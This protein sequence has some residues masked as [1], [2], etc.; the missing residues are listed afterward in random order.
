MKWWSAGLAVSALAAGWGSV[1]QAEGPEGGPPES[2]SV[3]S[4]TPS[5]CGDLPWTGAAWTELLR[6]ELAAD[7]TR[8]HVARANDPAKAGAPRM[9]LEP[10]ACDES[11]RSATLTLEL[12][13]DRIERAVD[14]AQVESRTRARVLALAAVELIHASRARLAMEAANAPAQEE[15]HLP[16]RLVAMGL[17]DHE[18]EPRRVHPFGLFAAGDGRVFVEGGAALLGARV[19][20]RVPLLGWSALVIDG[21]FLLGAARDP[22]G[23][24]DAALASVGLGALAMGGSDR[25]SLG[26][27]PRIEVGLAS[28][29]GHAFAPTT[30]A[31]SVAS[32]LV[33]LSVSGLASLRIAGAWSGLIGLDAGSTLYSYGARADGRK[34]SDFA[35]PMVGLRLGLMWNAR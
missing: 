14:L 29:T 4:V 19:G 5:T 17:P 25:V 32:P 2:I 22:L 27:G 9:R 16:T 33:V 24:V 18:P 31:A 12:G 3:I 28:F 26:V 7:G 20:A 1:A 15:P 23:D 13:T 11:A 6:V 8:V 10:E 30:A 35:G 21:G 34:V